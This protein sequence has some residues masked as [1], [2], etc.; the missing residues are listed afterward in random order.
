[1]AFTVV[2]YK[3]F[4]FEI[5]QKVVK[6]STKQ[7]CCQFTMKMW[8]WTVY[9]MHS[10]CMELFHWK[11]LLCLRKE[12]EHIPTMFVDFFLS[13]P[14]FLVPTPVPCTRIPMK[15]SIS[16]RI[17]FVIVWLAHSFFFIISRVNEIDNTKG[18]KCSLITDKIKS[19]FSLKAGGTAFVV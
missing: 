12:R 9:C 1:M 5:P 8:L 19:D 15:Q 4:N 14:A 3:S 11:I 6:K 10:Y 13:A 18:I 7:S 16:F 2:K 17:S